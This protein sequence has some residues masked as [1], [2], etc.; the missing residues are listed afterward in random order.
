MTELCKLAVKYGTDKFQKHHYTEVY[1]IYFN[2]IRYKCMNILEIGVAHG[3]SIKMWLDYFP[4]SQIFGMDI[5]IPEFITNN[6]GNNDIRFT[7]INGSQYNPNDLDNIIKSG[8]NFDIII[9]DGSHVAEHQQFSFVYLWKYLKPNGIYAIEDLNCPRKTYIDTTVD[10][11]KRF[12]KTKKL[13]SG[14]TFT[15][16]NISK[17]IH[18]CKFYCNDKILFIRK[19][20]K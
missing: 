19:K 16:N 2:P 13:M 5:S 20:E 4:N 18:T 1:S 3:A 8:K 6:F 10:V 17:E 15:N 11:F 12:Q 14:I 7:F 9:D